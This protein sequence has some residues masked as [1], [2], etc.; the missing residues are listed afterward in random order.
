M[1]ERGHFELSC[2]VEVQI[3]LIGKNTAKVK[4]N[5]DGEQKEAFLTF[6]GNHSVLLE[7]LNS[8]NIK[9]LI[10]YLK[11]KSGIQFNTVDNQEIIVI[12]KDD[13]LL[14]IYSIENICYS[15]KLS[16]ALLKS[17]RIIT[18]DAFMYTATKMHFLDFLRVFRLIDLEI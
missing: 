10:D 9:E 2:G 17:K 5:L 18:W 13:S 11:S 12:P 6:E 14:V 3:S 16:K 15:K 7:H 1:S 4:Y 8:L